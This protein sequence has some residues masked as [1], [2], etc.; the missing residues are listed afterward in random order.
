MRD[1]LIIEPREVHDM[2]QK[3]ERFLLLDCRE[4]WEH[5]T[6]RIEGATLIPMRQIPQKLDE[7]PKDQPVVVYCHAGMRSFNA[8]TWLKQQGV[9]ALS[10][11]GGSDRW[12]MEIDPKVPRY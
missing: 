6:A 3:G 11:T 8:A 1:E 2:M 9:N 4:P 5:Q 12:S 7:I 10:M